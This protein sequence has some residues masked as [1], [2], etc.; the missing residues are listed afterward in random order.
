ML[1]FKFD[2]LTHYAPPAINTE[3]HVQSPVFSPPSTQYILCLK[4]YELVYV[5]LLELNL[6]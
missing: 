2:K 5:C 3:F 6:K 4:V 1:C